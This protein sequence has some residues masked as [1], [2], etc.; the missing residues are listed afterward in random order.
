MQQLTESFNGPRV[1]TYAHANATINMVQNAIN[2]VSGQ[3]SAL[4]ALQNR[5]EHTISNLDNVSENTQSA[6][7][8]IRDTDM[9]DEMVRYSKN[10]SCSGWSVNA[11][12][13]KSEHTG[14]IILITVI[15]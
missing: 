2:N 11:C 4:G 9:A 12:S 7:S 14:S 6:E 3:R 8:R 10:N 1:D 5:L 13:G 15:G